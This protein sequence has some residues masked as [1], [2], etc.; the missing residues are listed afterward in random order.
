MSDRARGRFVSII[1]FYFLIKKK[2]FFFLKGLNTID[3][4]VEVEVVID[5]HQEDRHHVLDFL[6]ILIRFIKKFIY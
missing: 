2:Y 5:H 4:E 3:Q 1:L 6:L